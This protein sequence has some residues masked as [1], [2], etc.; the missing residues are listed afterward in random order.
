M[1]TP[2]PTPKIPRLYYA[3]KG[4]HLFW[5]PDYYTHGTCMLHN[6]VKNLQEGEAM[7]RQ[8]VKTGDIYCQEITKSAWCKSMWYFRVDCQECPPQAMAINRDTTMGEFLL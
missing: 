2:E 1:D 8:F 6:L 5:I 7:L 3:E 4:Q